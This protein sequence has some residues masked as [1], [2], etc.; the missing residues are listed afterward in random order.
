MGIG[1]GV[2]AAVLRFLNDLLL[3]TP[4]VV[5]ALG[6]AGLVAAVLALRLGR[7]RRRVAASVVA[8]LAALLLPAA[9]ADAVNAHYQYLPRV[10]DLL[11][12][13]TWP[14]APVSAARVS[15]AARGTHPTGA[16]VRIPVPGPLSGFGTHTALVY[17]PPQYFTEPA[18][19]F[20]AVYLLHGSP[21]AP[22]DWFRAARAADAGL[23]AARAG[24]PVILVAPRASRYWSD[25]SE[26]VDRPREHVATYLTRDVPAV[27]DATLRTLPTRSARAIAGNSAGGYC[28]LNLGLRHREE[29]SVILDMSGYDRPTYA[30]GMRGL[31]GRQ[32]G[33]ARR[34]RAE[35]PV[36]YV[37]GMSPKPR[38]AVWLDSGTSDPAALTDARVMASLL[39]RAGQPTVLRERA[40]G[41]DYGVWRPALREALLW[42]APRLQPVP[43]VPA[44]HSPAARHPL[45]EAGAADWDAR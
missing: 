15:A 43:A 13:P 30:G 33:L 7:H 34:V 40:G 31:F 6:A 39:S 5:I 20:P 28:A 21:G 32:P 27:V 36:A 2:V 29:F 23:A 12:Q 3:I 14:T 26:C 25:D 35:S 42:A 17:L 44:V 8:V 38:T 19:R 10:A 1:E 22:I 24:N 9:A 11:N 18:R 45:V 37:P 16:V 4:Q 41:H